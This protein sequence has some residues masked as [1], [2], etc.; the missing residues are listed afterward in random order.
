MTL[1]RDIP[2]TDPAWLW[3]GR[4]LEGDVSGLAGEGESGK[5]HMMFDV[6]ARVSRGWPMPPYAPD[7]PSAPR[8]TP[9][10]VIIICPEDKESSTKKPRLQAAGADEGMVDDLSRV[11]RATVDGGT[12][13]GSFSLPGD[14]GL[15][16][17][18]IAELGDVRLVIVN[19]LMAIAT[20]SVAGNQQVRSKI[21]E[22]MQ[23]LAE[24]T[25]TAIWVATHF[26]KGTT[27]ANIRDRIAGS[28]GL[29]DALR[30][31]TAIMRRPGGI[32]VVLALK[33][34]LV[35][36]TGALEYKIGGISPESHVLWKMPQP[37]LAGDTAGRLESAVIKVIGSAGRP[38]SAQKIAAQTGMT[39]LVVRQLLAAALREGR[40]VLINGAYAVPV[41]VS[42]PDPAPGAGPLAIEAPQPAS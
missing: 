33:A 31:W 10:Y 18:R 42:Q 14:I 9:G 4:I 21:I 40:V 12:M 36:V 20:D 19:P 27:I 3:E 39:F 22:P 2:R 32:R 26:T 23:A 41:P 24:E 5:D 28:K 25:G 35:K 37:A 6:A 13:R 34:S 11:D 7:D 30:V 17:E 15:L 29:Y 38:V 1:Y 16:R 8:A